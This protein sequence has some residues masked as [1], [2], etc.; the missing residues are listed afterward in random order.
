MRQ[1]RAPALKGKWA[2]T[3]GNGEMKIAWLTQQNRERL[4]ESS[5]YWG[6]P[7][8]FS[9]HKGSQHLCRMIQLDWHLRVCRWT[10]SRTH[11][12]LELYIG[13]IDFLPKKLEVC[14]DI[15]ISTVYV[16]VYVHIMLHLKP[17]NKTVLFMCSS[18]CLCVCLLLIYLLYVCIYS[19]HCDVYPVASAI[20]DLP[21]ISM[22][23]WRVLLLNL[24]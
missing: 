5:L 17:V 18:P 8:T 10:L 6:R 9:G 1:R 13:L 24:E 21:W 22:S 7:W 23:V 2:E 11:F 19:V 12:A 16:C 4:W 14:G 3:Q 15:W 20:N